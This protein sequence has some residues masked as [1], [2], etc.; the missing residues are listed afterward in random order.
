[1]EIIFA[2]ETLL[3]LYENCVYLHFT[4]ESVIK[5]MSSLD[6]MILGSLISPETCCLSSQHVTTCSLGC[7][8]FCNLNI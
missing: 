8:C 5:M 7:I 6:F 1:M 3:I 2:Y 4:E